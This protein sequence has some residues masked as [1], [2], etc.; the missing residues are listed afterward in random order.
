[1]IQI[2]P[3]IL[4]ADFSL[5]KEE[6]SKLEKAK[7]NYIHFDVMDNHFVPNLTFGS[8]FIK[9][10]RKYTKIPFDVHLM[11]D[12]PDD[13]IDEFLDAGG[14]IYT[15]HI[16][17]V[18]NVNKLANRVKAENRKFSLSVKPK[19]PIETILP[20][21]DILDMILI[22]SV[23]PGFGGQSLI[24]ETLTKISKLK[25]IITSKGLSIPVEIDGGV[26]L[27][28]LQRVVESGADILV[29]GSAFFKNEDYKIFMEKV[30]NNIKDLKTLNQT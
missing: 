1:M 21:L 12:S 22:M 16:E 27:S 3:S 9:D 4:S 20:Y 19:T 13:C 23:E 24:E 6:L 17:A 8:K 14:D 2:A 5:I 10:L 26:N 15:F 28:T 30:Y 29:M 18:R 25:N 7:V 11:I